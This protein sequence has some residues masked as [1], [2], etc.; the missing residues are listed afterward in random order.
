MKAFRAKGFSPGLP[1]AMDMD[2][3][4][5]ASFFEE[6]RKMLMKDALALADDNV[7]EGI[8]MINEFILRRN[9]RDLQDE[10]AGW[11]KEIG[12]IEEKGGDVAEGKK[13]LE[14]FM[15]LL[16]KNNIKEARVLKEGIVKILG[17]LHKDR[18]RNEVGRTLEKCNLL[19]QEIE[20]MKGDTIQANENI[21]KATDYLSGELLESAK[22]ISENCLKDLKTQRNSLLEE[23]ASSVL[24]AAG[25]IVKG[26]ENKTAKDY[27]LKARKAYELER[28][29]EALRMARESMKHM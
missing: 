4:Q 23:R 17:S 26:T 24:Y 8:Y 15:E 3:S 18:F 6:S 21:K 14:R 9:I 5:A 13:K 7:S 20:T 27:Y 11:R 29:K 10:A 22:E 2:V 1:K 12:E 19:L 28:Y 25:E 16:K